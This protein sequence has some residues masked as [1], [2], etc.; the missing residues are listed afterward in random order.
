MAHPTCVVAVS[1][2]RISTAHARSSLDPT[3]EGG[4]NGLGPRR[5]GG[6]CA[7]HTHDAFVVALA[8]LEADLQVLGRQ[9]GD[10]GVPPLDER[11]ALVVEQLADPEVDQLL[12][13]FEAVGVDVDDGEPAVVG[14]HDD[15]RRA[16]DRLLHPEGAAE[17][18]HE[19][20]LPGAEVAGE[21]EQVARPGH[22]RQLLR[23]APAC[24]RPT[25]CEPSARPRSRGQSVEGVFGSHEVGA[26]L[27]Q[28]LSATAEHRRR[29]VRRHEHPVA[30]RIAATPHLG[31]AV[32]RV[33]QELGREVAQGDD[34]L[35]VD[36]VELLLEE[37][38][39]R[40]DLVR[41][42]VPVARRPAFDD[43][44][45]VAT[46]AREPDLL[47]HQLVEQLAGLA[48]EGLALEVLLLA[49]TLSN[50]HEIGLRIADAEHHLGAPLR[51]RAADAGARLC[52]QLNE[53]RHRSIVPPPYV[54]TAAR[55]AWTTAH[56]PRERTVSTAAGTS[57]AEAATMASPS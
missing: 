42:R 23:P 18:L 33:E 44:R 49:R 39:A 52:L 57:P 45:D 20:R 37:G 12:E 16:R 47:E 54:R 15:E 22:A 7:V 32:V 29:V 3:V 1:M 56:A 35:W 36:E 46:I 17:A 40:R 19:R 50:E 41:Q 13:V 34:D 43:V 21:Q 25:W 6:A 53:G 30:V 11:D 8:E 4:A 38:P 2:P 10:H 28:R 48:Y 26:H 24:R 55:T 51:E 5:P 27:G 14:V 31:D 9:G